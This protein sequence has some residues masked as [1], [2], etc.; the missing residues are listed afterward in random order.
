VY[1]NSYLDLGVNK[2][3]NKKRKFNLEFSFF[4]VS[5]TDRHIYLH[6]NITLIITK[7]GIIKM[8]TFYR[9]II[10]GALFV[11]GL[12]L[13]ENQAQAKIITLESGQQINLP[14]KY[15]VRQPSAQDIKDAEEDSR[16][17]NYYL[18]HPN[19]K[20]GKYPMELSKGNDTMQ[21]YL[22]REYELFKGEKTMKQIFNEHRQMYNQSPYDR[23]MDDIAGGLDVEGYYVPSELYTYI[24]KPSD[25]TVYNETH[26]KNIDTALKYSFNQWEKDPH[27]H[28]RL[29]NSPNDARIVIKRAQSGTQLEDNIQGKFTAINVYHFVLLQGQIDLSSS[30]TDLS[31]ND[32]VLVHV[33]MH[34]LGH[35]LGKSDIY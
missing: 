29:V 35:A 19:E 20:F 21:D 16:I 14:D 24:L 23:A 2:C 32:P 25:I 10:F 8:K 17:G 3:E 1:L 15:F 5:A 6:Y 31:G 12:F 7:R 22:N 13:N 27:V 30:I 9:A 4:I 28:F 18:D 33:V 26:Q 34:E 11:F